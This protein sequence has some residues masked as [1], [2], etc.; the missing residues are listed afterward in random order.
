MPRWGAGVKC[1]GQNAFGTPLERLLGKLAALELPGHA[2]LGIRDGAGLTT[3]TAERRERCSGARTELSTRTRSTTIRRRRRVRGR[4]PGEQHGD[5]VSPSALEARRN[6][7]AL[8]R[9]FYAPTA[10]WTG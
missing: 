6:A 2:D 10:R 5:L 8:A 9:M 7:H 1:G 3:A 4:Q